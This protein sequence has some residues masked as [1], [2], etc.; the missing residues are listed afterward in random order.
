MSPLAP[1]GRT[2]SLRGEEAPGALGSVPRPGGAGGATPQRVPTEAS[3]PQRVSPA[4]GAGSVPALRPAVQAG[5]WRASPRACGAPRKAQTTDAERQA[6]AGTA[7][8]GGTQP[9]SRR[10]ALPFLRG[11]RSA[12]QLINP[13]CEWPAETR[14]ERNAM[15]TQRPGETLKGETP[16]G[17]GNL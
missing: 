1:G 17:T 2:G 3:W 8:A 16:T 9:A 13:R 4:H 12:L 7:R 10:Q 11:L 15:K 5:P 6:P 14:Q